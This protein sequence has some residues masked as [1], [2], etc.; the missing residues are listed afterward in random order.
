MSP[1]AGEA[2]T[3]CKGCISKR[4]CRCFA[5]CFA[6]HD[7]GLALYHSPLF[8]SP[9][10]TFQLRP[11]GRL[12]LESILPLCAGVGFTQNRADP[13]SS[14]SR[15]W[16]HRFRLV[17]CW[18]RQMKPQAVVRQSDVCPIPREGMVDP[19]IRHLTHLETR[20]AVPFL[21]VTQSIARSCDG[22]GDEGHGAGFPQDGQTGIVAR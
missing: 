21:C 9:R 12:L 1:T 11:L 6:L 20:P 8:H 10:L 4:S 19:S 3:I 7:S 17:N 18:T 15:S 2:Y 14:C 22:R 5:L 13:A 16:G